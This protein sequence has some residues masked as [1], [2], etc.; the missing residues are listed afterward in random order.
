VHHSHGVLQAYPGSLLQAQPAAVHSH[1]GALQAETGVLHVHPGAMEAQ[2]EAM[3]A[4]PEAKKANL[5]A[6]EVHPGALHAFAIGTRKLT[7]EPCIIVHTGTEI[8]SLEP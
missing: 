5:K 1:P 4:N 3:K 8:L 6:M 2:P 7:L